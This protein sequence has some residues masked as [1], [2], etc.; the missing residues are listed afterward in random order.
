MKL[1]L[2]FGSNTLK[3]PFTNATF[4]NLKYCLCFFFTLCD[5]DIK[6]HWHKEGTYFFYITGMGDSDGNIKYVVY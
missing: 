3:A 5:T 6:I 4:L 2:L 1:E